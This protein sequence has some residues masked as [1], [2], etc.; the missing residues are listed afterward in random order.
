MGELGE[1]TAEVEET[2]RDSFVMAIKA[3]GNIS[4]RAPVK[5]PGARYQSLPILRESDHQLIEEIAIKHKFDYVVVPE[6]LT[7]RDIAEVK[8]ALGKDGEQIHVIAKI[9]TVE[10]IQNFT[11]ILKAADGVVILRNELA[12]DMEPEKLVIAQKWMTQ[13]ANAAAIPVFLQS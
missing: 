3:G 1:V 4:S 8:Q 11:A 9:A 13:T 5:L 10:A 6:V 7:G 2:S 12:F